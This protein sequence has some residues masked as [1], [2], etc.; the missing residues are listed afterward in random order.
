[1]SHSLYDIVGMSYTA[2]VEADLSLICSRPQANSQSTNQCLNMMPTGQIVE[3]H[4]C[5]V[6][7]V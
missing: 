3:V 6:P 1:M 4:T 5:Y 2:H 7:T